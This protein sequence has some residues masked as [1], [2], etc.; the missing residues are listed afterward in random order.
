[1][2]K[3]NKSDYEIGWDLFLAGRADSACENYE[4]ATGWYDACL[5]E[6]RAQQADRL[7]CACCDDD[8][9]GDCIDDDYEWWGC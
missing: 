3:L 1:M 9:A 2:N 8:D 6:V 4:Q 5:A 7:R